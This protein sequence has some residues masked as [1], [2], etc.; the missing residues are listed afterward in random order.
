MIYFLIY[1]LIGIVIVS[2]VMFL[3]RSSLKQFT[4]KELIWAGGAVIALWPLLVLAMIY[5]A[6]GE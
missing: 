5:N 6:I 1:L 2:W 3:K 4:F